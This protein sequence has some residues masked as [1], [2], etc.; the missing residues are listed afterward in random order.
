M[1]EQKNI[2]DKT[3]LFIDPAGEVVTI[4]NLEKFCRENNLDRQNMGNVNN[5]RFPSA[6]GWRK[7]DPAIIGIPYVSNSGHR[8]KTFRIKSPSGEI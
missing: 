8:Q 1:P 5:G 4:F 2:E 7:Y 6:R 3:Y